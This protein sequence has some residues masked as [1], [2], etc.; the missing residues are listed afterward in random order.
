M[1]VSFFCID[2]C[3]DFEGKLLT[4]SLPETVLPAYMQGQSF[5]TVSS[6]SFSL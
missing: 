2:S 5:F 1:W 6:L 4:L 3:S